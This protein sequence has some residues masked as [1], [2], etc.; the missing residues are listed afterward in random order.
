M[1]VNSP[2]VALYAAPSVNAPPVRRVWT[3]GGLTQLALVKLLMIGLL[4]LRAV[5]VE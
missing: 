2:D 4:T 3:K 5:L 1:Y